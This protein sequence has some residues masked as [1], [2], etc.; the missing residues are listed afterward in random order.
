MATYNKS[1]AYK[2]YNGSTFVTTWNED[3]LSVPQFSSVING[4][5]GNLQVRLNRTFQAFGEDVDIALGNSVRV[6]CYDYDEPNGQLIYYGYISAYKPVLEGSREYVEVTLLPAFSRAND[7]MLL[8]DNELDTTVTYNSYDPSN[9]ISEIVEK[10]LDQGVDYP[11]YGSSLWDVAVF[12]ESGFDTD[13]H[14]EIE[15]SNT[16]VSYTFNT[17][18]IKEAVDKVIELAPADWYYA[19]LPDGTLRFK[20]R[21]TTIDHRLIIGKNIASADYEQRSENI[22]NDV[23]FIGGGD[24]PLFYRYTRQGSIDAYG[25]RVKKIVDG[26]VTVAA[27]AQTMSERVLDENELPEIRLK[28]RIVDNNGYNQDRGYDIESIKVG[29]V[30]QI[31]NIS[32]SMET[33][34][35]WDNALWDVN[36]WDYTLQSIVESGLLVVRTAYHPDYLEVETSSRFP[37]VPKRIE[38][39]NRNLE[40]TQTENNPTAPTLVEG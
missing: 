5:A 20:A 11:D 24:P 3:V 18:T 10:F 12:D 7:F 9:M 15:T 19:V 38:D 13:R 30:L 32:E 26:R 21:S 40:T 34:V 23:Y 27:T 8:G 37:S 4:T 6:Y 1:F 17:N 14:F 36:V 33:P 35:S 16:V 39:I 29:D 31:K 25:R 2:V 22:V 28:L